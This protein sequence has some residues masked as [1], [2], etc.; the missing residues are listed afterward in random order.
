VELSRGDTVLSVPREF[1]M[2][3][4]SARASAIG[5]VVKAL[6]GTFS[7]KWLLTLHLLHEYF[8]P[9][10]K[11]R[12]YL[13]TIPG[14]PEQQGTGTHALLWS[15]QDFAELQCSP[16]VECPV[17]ARAK[18]DRAD[19]KMVFD[20][21]SPLMAP[22]YASTPR[23][24]TWERFAWAYS[25]VKAR[26]F[27][28]NV[29]E[30]YGTRFRKADPSLPRG[31][32]SLL[33]PIGDLFNH[34][35]S[36]PALQFA[37]EFNDETDSLVVYAD[38]DYAAGDEVFISYGILTNP[39]LLLSYGF[40]MPDNI[41]ETV[42]FRLGMDA[43]GRWEDAADGAAGSAAASGV[44]PLD[45]LKGDLLRDRGLGDALETHIGVDGR[46]S[47][48][49]MEALRIR[50]ATLEGLVPRL[51]RAKRQREDAAAAA[52]AA[53]GGR[54]REGGARPWERM[55]VPPP[56]RDFQALNRRCHPPRPRFRREEPPRLVRQKQPILWVARISTTS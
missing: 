34:H 45:A 39:D 23:G 53:G 55:D 33:V 2:S 9:A 35:N 29:T 48:R 12:A 40:V 18:E 56:L 3:R 8:D 42:G 36:V 6:E 32:M 13:D 41:F 25:T 5:S 21:L 52:A 46:P 38:Q 54:R 1:F 51:A 28:I 24:L 17:V 11:W 19:A 22:F 37:Y 16:D 43:D 47:A 14:P 49:F 26:C 10:S 20:E 15:D 30:T 31:L 44:T 50:E 4:A 27:T 7:D